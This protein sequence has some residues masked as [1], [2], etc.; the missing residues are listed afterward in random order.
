MKVLRNLTVV[1]PLVLLAV[2]PLQASPPSTLNGNVFVEPWTA[3]DFTLSDQHGAPFHMVDT[4]GKVVVR[5]VHLH[6]LY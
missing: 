1:A 4:K 2:A 5:D 3:S 6:A